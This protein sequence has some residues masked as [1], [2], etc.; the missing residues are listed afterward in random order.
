[1]NKINYES[2]MI[3]LSLAIALAVIQAGNAFS[4]EKIKRTEPSK[5]K[6]GLNCFS[7]NQPLIA[8]TMTVEDMFRIIATVG[9][10]AADLTGYY[11]STTSCIFYFASGCVSQQSGK[12]Y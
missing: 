12:I 5:V 9:F 8:K 7:F 4:I 3:S 2:F 11:F 1:M 6:I 10:E